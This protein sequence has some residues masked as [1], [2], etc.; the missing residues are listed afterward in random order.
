MFCP[1]TSS[2]LKVEGIQ[3]E[4]PRLVRSRHQQTPTSSSRAPLP[5]QIRPQ[6]ARSDNLKKDEQAQTQA[7]THGPGK[8][9]PIMITPIPEEPEV[10][11][12]GILEDWT[13]HA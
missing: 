10:C 8:V 5:M 6:S 2:Y 11:N 4:K 12:L 7:C 13:N 1:C 3:T 9:P